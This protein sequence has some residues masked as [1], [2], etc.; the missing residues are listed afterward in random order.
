MPHSLC[1]QR[2]AVAKRLA[3]YPIKSG[4]SFTKKAVKY[5]ALKTLGLRWVYGAFVKACGIFGIDFDQL[6][7]AAVRGF[8]GNDLIRFYAINHRPRSSPYS[9]AALTV[10]AELS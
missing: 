2:A 6:T 1:N 5:I 7:V 3:D 9:A 4:I 8:K 10:I